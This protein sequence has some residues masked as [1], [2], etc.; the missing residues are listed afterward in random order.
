MPV[1]SLR[2]RR[3]IVEIEFF[4]RGCSHDF[5]ILNRNNWT[6]VAKA[7]ASTTDVVVIRS[8]PARCYGLGSFGNGRR[9]A[10]LA[11]SSG[12][13]LVGTG[14]GRKGGRSVLNG[15]RSGL[16]SQ[17]LQEQGSHTAS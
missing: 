4:E 12:I 10:K 9:S 11:G 3:C 17:K 15:C 14:D 2:H 1:G 8:A 7:C 16:V 6:L 13:W 5:N